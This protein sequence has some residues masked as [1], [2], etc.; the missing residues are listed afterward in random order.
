MKRKKTFRMMSFI[1][2]LLLLFG[3]AACGEKE[4]AKEIDTLADAKSDLY[5]SAA[6]LESAA[7]LVVRAE[8]TET[9]ENVVK[10]LGVP[11]TQYGYTLSM[12]KVNEIMKNTSGR[13]MAVGDEIRV[14]ENQFTYVDD[15]NTKVTCHVNQYKMMEPGN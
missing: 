12:V 8:R 10:D 2:M 7:T 1:F 6:E 5:E 4:V 14:L 11:N 9:A 13:D 3:T 15:E